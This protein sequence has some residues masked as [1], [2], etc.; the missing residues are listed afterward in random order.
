MITP[1]KPSI[2]AKLMTIR[3]KRRISALLPSQGRGRGLGQ[4]KAFNTIVVNYNSQ[5]NTCG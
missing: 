4:T 1:Q 2:E 3:C 5:F